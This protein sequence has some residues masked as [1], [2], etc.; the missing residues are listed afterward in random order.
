MKIEGT[1][2]S[3]Y[4]FR[5]AAYSWH[6]KDRPEL[7][8]RGMFPT[9]TLLVEHFNKIIERQEKKN[10]SKISIRSVPCD[11]KESSTHSCITTDAN[12]SSAEPRIGTQCARFGTPTVVGHLE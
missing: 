6:K 12:S 5:C 3:W 10:R 8:L 2:T 4:S 1:V 7:H 11:M 9:A